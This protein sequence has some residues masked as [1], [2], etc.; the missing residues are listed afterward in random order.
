[1][2]ANL[3]SHVGRPRAKSA[4]ACRGLG[5]RS[6]RHC[7]SR[8]TV[9]LPHGGFGPLIFA[10]RTAARTFILRGHPPCTDTSLLPCSPPSPWPPL[11]DATKRKATLPKSQRRSKPSREPPREP[12]SR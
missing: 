9:L 3:R 5:L 2:G 7:C 4:P 10:L 8:G 12:S 6:K 11:P 1:M